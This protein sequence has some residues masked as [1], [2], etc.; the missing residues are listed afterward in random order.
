MSELRT[1]TISTN[2]T[3][4]VAID[5]SLNLKSYSTTDRDALTSVAGDV[6][7][8]TTTSKVQ[9]YSG[10]SWND[11]GSAT[12]SADFLIV[13]GGGGGG[14]SG[15][16][17]LGSGGAGAGGLLASYNNENTGGGG[18]SL[19]SVTIIA[20]GT[21]TYPVTIGAGGGGFLGAD[22]GL[23][24]VG[25]KSQFILLASGGMPGGYRYEHNGL[26][27]GGSGGGGATSNNSGHGGVP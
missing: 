4:N 27:P 25:N 1:N 18:S 6:I 3:N 19:D 17:P 15:S 5:N 22:P 7:Y 9:V 21:T 14:G 10:S 26:Y 24:N 8:N 23:G 13:A 12:F 11:T 16:A 2:D 20:D